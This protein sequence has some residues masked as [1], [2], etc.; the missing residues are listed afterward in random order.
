VGPGDH[1]V[2]AALDALG[3]VVGDQPGLLE[4]VEEDLVESVDVGQL[5]AVAPAVDV[6]DDAPP[7]GGLRHVL[8]LGFAVED[9]GL[10]LFGLGLLRPVAAADLV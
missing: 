3:V 7:P 10:G 1:H 5:A 2:D 8:L 4:G 6:Q 9:Q